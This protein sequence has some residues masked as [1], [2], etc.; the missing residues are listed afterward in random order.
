MSNKKIE[1]LEGQLTHAKA[2]LEV[3][4]RAHIAAQAEYYRLLC[5]LNATK[6]AAG[7]TV[8]QEGETLC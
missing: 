4:E 3:K 8:L 6:T 5:E 7:E 2:V 1:T